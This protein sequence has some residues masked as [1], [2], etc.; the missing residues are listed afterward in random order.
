MHARVK[1]Y[2]ERGGCWA[3]AVEVV[4]FFL[5]GYSHDELVVGGVSNI[6]E[7]VCGEDERRSE[8]AS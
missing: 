4:V 8:A 1:V 3:C 6:S 2:R 7:V 5:R